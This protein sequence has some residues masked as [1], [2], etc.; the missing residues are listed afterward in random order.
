MG[1]LDFAALR[2]SFGSSREDANFDASMDGNGNDVI[3][4]LDFAEFV[5]RLG[6]RF[7]RTS[8]LSWPPLKGWNRRLEGRIDGL[9]L[10]CMRD[11]QSEFVQN[12]KAHDT[13]QQLQG[14][15][16]YFELTRPIGM[17]QSA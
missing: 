10:Y 2:S 5:L 9:S 15:T 6:N 1:L 11:S 3:D 4:L 16:E 7:S 13:D 14:C 8:L 17:H 12:D